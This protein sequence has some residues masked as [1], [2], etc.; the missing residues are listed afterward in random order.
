M[1]H[2]FSKIVFQ[3]KNNSLINKWRFS[4][5]FLLKNNDQIIQDETNIIVLFSGTRHVLST[6]SLNGGFR[7][8]LDA[9]FNH[10][11]KDP[12][13]GYC[14]MHGATYKNHLQYIA[15]ELGLS[16]KKVC[17]LSTAVDLS[18]AEI[19]Q[20][21]FQDYTVTVICSGGVAHNGRRAGD[22]TT[23]WEQDEIYHV[24]QEIIPHSSG[25][26]NI[27]LHIDAHLSEGAMATALMVATEAKAATIRDFNFKSCY[28]DQY[29]SGSGTDGVI[30]I[31]DT[32][33]QT[34]LYHAATDVKLGECI[35]KAVS[36]AL[37]D[38]LIKQLA[39]EEQVNKK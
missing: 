2:N 10:C 7:T 4:H 9:V 33:S 27:I 36:A 15:N 19:V 37:K 16:P 32:E 21:S 24:E 28:S 29:T 1:I 18:L 17:G 26:V 38:Q 12:V 25:T 3:T 8:D 35:G 23:M 6:S 13:T 20:E 22:P 11:D 31:C 5:M 34:H 39:Y 30:V 14:E